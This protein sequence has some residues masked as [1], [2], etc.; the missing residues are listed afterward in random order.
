MNGGDAMDDQLI[1]TLRDAQRFGFFGDR[2]IEEAAGHSIAFVDAIGTL[3]AGTRLVDLGSGGGLPGLV[4]ADHYRH[5]AITL[6]DRR[7]KRTDFLRRATRRLE[8]DHVE[9]VTADVADL[10]RHVA[11]GTIS[12]FDVATARGFG[13][14]A[15]TL[16]YA[17]GLVHEHGRIVISEPPSG[18]RWDSDVVA[19]LDVERSALGAVSVFRRRPIE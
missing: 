17:V 10:C 8:F 14:P 15:V 1:E 2:P 4:L 11:R 6:V 19:G 7:Q 5:V 12:A 13:P 16:R 9:I 18:D 3:A